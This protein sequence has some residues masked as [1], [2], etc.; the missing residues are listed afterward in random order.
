MIASDTSMGVALARELTWSTAGMVGSNC[1][2]T[3]A[4][5]PKPARPCWPPRSETGS[6]GR[7]KATLP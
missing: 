6:K 2:G 1:I 3:G 7:V 5:W 4:E